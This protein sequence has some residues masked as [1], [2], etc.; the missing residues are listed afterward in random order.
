MNR[1]SHRAALLP[2]CAVLLLAAIA[3]PAYADVAATAASSAVAAG[4]P[5]SVVL[6]QPATVATVPYGDYIVG[7]AQTIEPWVITIVTSLVG[8]LVSR[9][10]PLARLFL[11]DKVVESALQKWLDY[12]LNAVQGAAA[13]K[14]LD[15]DTGSAVLAQ[16]VNRAL[17]RA[18]LSK[19]GQILLD[20]A[21]G[22]AEVATK[23][24]RLLH[25]D[26]TGSDTVLTQVLSDLRAAGHLKA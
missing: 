19:Q 1:L 6:T 21:G 18:T 16:A 12:G 4:A 26:E 9:F 2:V 22:P 3:V 15:V 23:L 13:G 17:D 20:K 5:A 25:L 7:I 11:T 10:F 24:F 8:F 14:K